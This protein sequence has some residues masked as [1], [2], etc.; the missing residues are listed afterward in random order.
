[1]RIYYFLF[2]LKKSNNVYSNLTPLCYTTQVRILFF[3]N[4]KGCD[5]KKGKGQTP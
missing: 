1:M 5:T 4:M 2:V 3:I